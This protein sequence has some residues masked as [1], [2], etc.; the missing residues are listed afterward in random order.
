MA[1]RRVFSEGSESQPPVRK[2]G[3]E[4]GPGLSHSK[5]ND[6]MVCHLL[7]SLWPLWTMPAS[8]CRLTMPVWQLMTSAPSESQPEGYEL[9]GES[10]VPFLILTSQKTGV[11][12]PG[13]WGV[14]RDSNLGWERMG[15][16]VR[17][18][19]EVL[20]CGGPWLRVAT[21]LQVRSSLGF[22]LI[23]PSSSGTGKAGDDTRCHTCVLE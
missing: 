6:L 20:P 16:R 3:S 17:K 9:M 13:I 7:R 5:L 18:P 2:P 23:W 22:S 10:G 15:R 21:C 12:G 14:S 8:C 19:V 4:H 11:R 1:G